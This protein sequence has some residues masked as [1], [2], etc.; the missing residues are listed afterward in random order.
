MLRSYLLNL[1]ISLLGIIAVG[2]AVLSAI[3]EKAPVYLLGVHALL[4]LYLIYAL[5]SNFLKTYRE[6]RYQPSRLR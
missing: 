6:W 5:S 3:E 4:A 1:V 2:Y